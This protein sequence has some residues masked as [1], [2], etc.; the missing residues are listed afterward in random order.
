M[1]KQVPVS[2]VE[3]GDRIQGVC[4]TGY[5]K[6]RTF[7]GEVKSISDKT[8]IVRVARNGRGIRAVSVNKEDIKRVM[9]IS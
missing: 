3:V 5:Q 7:G 8:V 6:G 1:I 2:D 9:R 4:P